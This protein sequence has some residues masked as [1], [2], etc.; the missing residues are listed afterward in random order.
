MMMRFS[1]IWIA[2]LT[3]CLGLFACSDSGDA[4]TT[5]ST[6]DRPVAIAVAVIDWTPSDAE[7]QYAEQLATGVWEECQGKTKRP[8][9]FVANSG[10]DSVARIDLCNGAVV[11]SNIKGN[12]FVFSHIPV[13][14]FPVDVAISL[15]EGNTRAFVS[16]GGENSLSVIVTESART[17]RDTVPLSARPTSL[18]VAPSE[19]A[20]EGEVWVALPDLHR[21][22]RVVKQG[23][24]ESERWVEDGFAVL[25]TGVTPEPVPSGMTVHPNGRY[26][27]VADMAYDYFHIVD[28]EN[29]GYP[30]Q[31]RNVYGPQRNVAVTPDGRFLYLS[32]VDERKVAV[33]DLINDRYLDTNAQLPSHYNAPAPSDEFEYDIELQAVPRTV[34]FA[35]LDKANPEPDDSDTD[36]DDATLTDGDEDLEVDGDSDGEVAEGESEGE[37]ETD[38]SES[39]RRLFAEESGDGDVDGD[40]EVE[41]SDDDSAIADDLEF[42]LY[43]YSVGY[44]GN[45]QIIDLN[46]NLHQLYDSNPDSG[47]ELS[48]LRDDELT[49]DNNL[50]LTSLD[51]TL[52]AERTPDALWELHYNGVIPGSDGSIAGRFDFANNRFYD[53]E[54]DFTLF[55]E[56]L[57][58]PTSSDPD[59]PFA[60]KGDL[61][62]IRDT[63]NPPEGDSLGCVEEIVGD[64]GETR[65]VEL[66]SVRLEIIDITPEYLVFDP[67]GV[68]LKRCFSTSVEY[69]VRANDNYIVSLTELDSGG[70]RL[71][72]SL[73]QGRAVNGEFRQSDVIQGQE[74]FES[75]VFDQDDWQDYICTIEKTNDEEETYKEYRFRTD[76]TLSGEAESVNGIRCRNS[77]SDDGDYPASFKNDLI[78]FSICQDESS[79]DIQAKQESTF[80]YSF[81][82]FSGTNEIQA[83]SL[84]DSADRFVGSLL[85]DA[86]LLDLYPNFPRLYAVD[87]SEE[88]VYV[89]DLKTD[90]VVT[91]IF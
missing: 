49:I 28:L 63:P 20:S 90:Q 81:R 25:D 82:T 77:E 68:D 76:M 64:D 22:A 55:E 83:I 88:I 23:A 59:D 58:R 74:Q 10:G 91:L 44:N 11:N 17:L 66:D 70:N 53:P 67:R 79:V 6:L 13:G 78:E 45:I 3:L 87:S 84:T 73:Y 27:Y 32:K 48:Y 61:L 41:A 85:E 24:D 42:L 71:S 34:V 57:A 75:L 5:V 72:S 60:L 16:N 51:T 65:L 37:G 40:A 21:L 14:R 33:Y 2:C 1:A 39:G 4:D 36:G 86:A 12:P 54:V 9:A 43:G 31:V 15:D 29:P 8:F 89:I 56:L 35:M 62:V 50:C 38:A 47:P 80:L 46:R 30:A 52:Y 69:L 26:L 19:A 7:L 18:V